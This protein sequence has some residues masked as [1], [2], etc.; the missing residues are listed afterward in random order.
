MPTCLPRRHGVPSTQ[1]LPSGPLSLDAFV[2]AGPAGLRGQARG[3]QICR[4]PSRPCFGHLSF[5]TRLFC[6]S[7]ASSRLQALASRMWPPVSCFAPPPRR[8]VFWTLLSNAAARCCRRPHGGVVGR[9]GP[10]HCSTD[11]PRD[12][13]PCAPVSHR[14]RLSLL[15]CWL[16]L[17]A[18]PPSPAPPSSSPALAP[19][20]FAPCPLRMAVRWVS[21]SAAAALRSRRAPVRP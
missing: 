10:S 2:T 3:L 6:P 12:N 20:S 11:P 18:M 5:R 16:F 15:P 13:V 21:S 17:A 4:M 9:E 1:P 14:P 7:P 19:N 8:S